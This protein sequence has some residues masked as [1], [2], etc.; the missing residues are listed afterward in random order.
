MK[1]RKIPEYWKYQLLKEQTVT[2]DIEADCHVEGRMVY[3]E[4][5]VLT[6][7]SHYAWDGPSGPTIDTK[8]FMRGSLFHDALYQLMRQGR[9][10]RIYRKYADQL[11]RQICLEDGMN[12]FRAWYVYHAVRIFAGSRVKAPKPKDNIVE[13]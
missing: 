8:T 6:T 3:I 12:K 10:D 7:Q 5:G 1:F 13:Y 9:L 2:V 11:L 4:G